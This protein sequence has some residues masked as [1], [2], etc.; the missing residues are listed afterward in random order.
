MGVVTGH[1]HGVPVRHQLGALLEGRRRRHRPDARHGGRLR[2]LPRIELPRAVP[3]RREAPGTARRTGWPPS[4]SSSARGSRA[5][6][7]SRRTPGCSIPSATRSDR[8]GEILLES[9]WALLLNPWLFWQYLHT[10]IGAVVT[11]SFVMA[12][13]G[14]FY[15]LQGKHEPYGRT[16]VRLG[17]ISG[18]AASVLIAFP[19]G[20][21][22]GVM[23]ARHQPATLAAMEGLFRSE[24]GAPLAIIGQPDVETA[25]ARQPPH[26]AARAELPHLQ[27][28]D[29]GGQGARRIPPGELAGQHPAALLQLSHHGR[30]GDALHRRNDCGGVEA[31]PRRALPVPPAAVG[32]HAGRPLPLHRQ[33]RRLD[34]RRGGPPAL[35]DLRPDA[36]RRRR[37]A[38]RLRRQHAVHPARLH[39]HVHASSPSC[40]SSW[41]GARSTTARKPSGTNTNGRPGRRRRRPIWRRFGS[42]WSR[43]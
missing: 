34:D 25:A 18:F 19:T 42:V 30:A 21:G 28:V 5:S 33:H 32:A 17:V 3:V 1:S 15:L 4:W 24:K 12:A 20:D 7:S 11:A 16:F 6:S 8:E 9:F 10:M 27:A 26:R 36:H 35:A 22:Q 39:R 40:S 2:L 23:L 38:A 14:A 43:S 41:C 29:G 37:F 13:V 31:L